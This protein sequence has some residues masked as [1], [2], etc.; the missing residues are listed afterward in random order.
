MFE[1]HRFYER[2]HRE[3][4]TTEKF[5]TDLRPLARTCNFVED[6]KGFTDQMIRDRLVCGISN[7]AV[8]QRLLAKE[9]PTL[10]AC[11]KECRIYETTASQVTEMWWCCT[12]SCE[13]GTCR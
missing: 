2:R 5:I 1:R 8:R 11:I 7:N 3:G 6:G 10:A 4:E 13:I 12:T 9:N